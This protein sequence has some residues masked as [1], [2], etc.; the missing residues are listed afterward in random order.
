[1]EDTSIFDF[2]VKHLAAEMLALGLSDLTSR[3][4]SRRADAVEWIRKN[5]L[6]VGGFRWCIT[7]C[8]VSGNLI[9]EMVRKITVEG[10]TFERLRMISRSTKQR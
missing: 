10:K 7:T 5:E 4:L 6:E 2:G 9:R 1:M 8:G 3:D